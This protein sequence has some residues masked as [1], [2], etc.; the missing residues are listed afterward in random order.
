M[1]SG[2]NF[3]AFSLTSLCIFGCTNFPSFWFS[4][5]TRMS[6]QQWCHARPS[7][8]FAWTSDFFFLLQALKLNPSDTRFFQMWTSCQ[9][10]QRIAV[11]S[12]FHPERSVKAVVFY[13]KK[14][15][16]PWPGTLA[17]SCSGKLLQDI[18]NFECW[19]IWSTDE[20]RDWN[21]KCGVLLRFVR[22]STVREYS[23]LREWTKIRILGIKLMFSSCKY[24]ATCTSVLWRM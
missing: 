1:R 18:S 19:S 7:V 4:T 24:Q 8:N 5:Y 23:H 2:C 21:L 15:A 9:L 16:A 20:V 11:L 13:E 3:I 22:K 12:P 10:V 14:L 17:A 6:G